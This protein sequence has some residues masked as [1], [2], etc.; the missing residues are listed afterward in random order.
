MRRWIVNKNET[1]PPVTF[2]G[3]CIFCFNNSRQLCKTSQGEANWQGKLLI[4]KTKLVYKLEF[5]WKS[6]GDIYSNKKLL[7]KKFKTYIM[8]AFMW[9]CK[10]LNENTSDTS[11]SDTHVFCICT[12]NLSWVTLWA[13]TRTQQLSLAALG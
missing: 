2:I 9:K 11:I 13:F 10:K 6:N 8:A 3:T 4:W 1:S 7:S 12:R 5:D